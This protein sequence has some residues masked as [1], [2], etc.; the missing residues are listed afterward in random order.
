[1]PN[2]LQ[3]RNARQLIDSLNHYLNGNGL[4][5]KALHGEFTHIVVP[6]GFRGSHHANLKRFA[7]SP[8]PVRLHQANFGRSHP[9][10]FGL[11]ETAPSAVM[12]LE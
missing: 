7:E 8:A 11:P 12:G 5:C 2:E 10:R 3:I 6:A 9:S 4:K 1:M